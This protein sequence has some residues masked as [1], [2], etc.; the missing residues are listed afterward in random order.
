MINLRH[1]TTCAMWAIFL[2]VLPMVVCS[3]TEVSECEKIKMSFWDLLQQSDHI[4]NVSLSDGC[5][6]QV[7]NKSTSLKVWLDKF[8]NI[9]ET[10]K[11]FKS[12]VRL[13]NNDGLV[14]WRINI[15]FSKTWDRTLGLQGEFKSWLFLRKGTDLFVISSPDTKLLFK[16]EKFLREPH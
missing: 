1:F 12:N 4:Y 3:Q 10:K 9:S 11:E 15:P 7:S 13:I 14:R 16:I 2:I 8:N 6:L 5:I